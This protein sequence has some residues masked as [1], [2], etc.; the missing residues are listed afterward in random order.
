MPKL[1]SGATMKNS[2]KTIENYL[3]NA[4][5]LSGH[6]DQ[7]NGSDVNEED[8]IAILNSENTPTRLIESIPF[9]ILQKGVDLGKLT[10]L[11][12]QNNL[13][14]KIGYLLEVVNKEFFKNNPPQAY[15]NIQVY[16][17]ILHQQKLQA[18]QFFNKYDTIIFGEYEEKELN[19]LEKK[20]KIHS[21][22]GF[23]NGL[24]LVENAK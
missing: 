22:L 15:D 20:W 12:I 14:N 13:Q 3:I 7:Y 4:G 17:E 21:K 9:I 11:A 24:Y 23:E 19:S 1:C 5:Y 2:E 6:L 16:I 10:K 18:K 8:L